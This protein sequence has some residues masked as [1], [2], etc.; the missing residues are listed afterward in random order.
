M[1]HGIEVIDLDLNDAKQILGRLIRANPEQ[2]NEDIG[3]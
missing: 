2:W 3:R 1:R